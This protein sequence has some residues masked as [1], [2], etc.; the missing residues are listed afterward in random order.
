MHASARKAKLNCSFAF[1][2]IYYPFGFFSCVR[3]VG[4]SRF[5]VS[6]YVFRDWLY[7]SLIF[8]G[9]ILSC[10]LVISSLWGI[11][12]EIGAA[13]KTGVLFKGANYRSDDACE[14]GLVG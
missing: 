1:C 2:P 6:D 4:Y 13:S 14:Y 8:S 10:A 7:R 11:L 5:F 3:I 9:Y 12:E